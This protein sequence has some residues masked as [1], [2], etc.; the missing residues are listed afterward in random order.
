M[1]VIVT[2]GGTTEKIDDV[3]GINNFSTGRLGSLIADEFASSGITE[4]I[5]IHG[6]H[7]HMPDNS[8][9]RSIGVES[10]RDLAYQLEKLI[11]EERISVVVHSM[12]VS[13]YFAN[14][15]ITDEQVDEYIQK[16]NPT[17]SSFWRLFSKNETKGKK[18]SSSSEDIIVRLSKNPKIISKIKLWD[19]NVLL[20]GFKLLVNVKKEE[21][22]SVAKK[23]LSKNDCQFVLAND[24]SLISG[25]N[26][27]AI[28]LNSEGIVE[29]YKTKQAIAQ[30]IV[31]AVLKEKEK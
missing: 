6:L 16:K 23:T 2:A 24:K 11:K 8:A 17:T 30:G 26:H 22:L 27:Q 25:D 20:V 13:D 21:L 10:A 9:V 18:M 19:P 7:A 4:V 1:K 3:R 14:G 28:L 29:E 15:V 5:Y 12:A 31:K